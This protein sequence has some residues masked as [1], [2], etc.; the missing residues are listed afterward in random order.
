LKSLWW[1]KKI[2]N[3]QFCEPP[4]VVVVVV[5]VVVVAVVVIVVVVVVKA[6]QSHYWPGV[7]QRVPGS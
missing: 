1:G 2:N 7:A 4:T 3:A 5:V 6:K